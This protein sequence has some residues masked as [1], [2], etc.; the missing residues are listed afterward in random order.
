MSALSGIKDLLREGHFSTAFESSRDL[1]KANPTDLQARSV[2]FELLSINGDWER[3]RSH[4]EAIV[5]LGADPMGWVGVMA[6]LHA[7]GQRDKVWAGERS[8]TVI[9]DLDDD[10]QALFSAVKAAIGSDDW[11]RVKAAADG[12]AFGPGKID[13]TAFSDLATADDRLPGFLEVAV[14]GEYGWLW[15]AAVRRM[16]FPAGPTNLTDVIWIPSR[17]FLIDG[18]VSEMTVFGCYPGTQHSADGE[19]KLG[20][21]LVWEEAPGD[22]AIGCGPQILWV[23]SETKSLHELRVIEF[24]SDDSADEGSMGDEAK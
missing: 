3:A 2:F 21:K 17:V 16:E 11:A 4:V 1:L 10:D 18:S 7:S 24:D 22:L 15:L 13:G 23:D 19:A 8:P 6:N 20:R 14:N 5:N 12:L 9:G